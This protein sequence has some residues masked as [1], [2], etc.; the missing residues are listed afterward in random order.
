MT[1]FK[2]KKKANEDGT[3]NMW[4]DPF[5]NYDGKMKMLI[6]QN[7]LKGPKALNVPN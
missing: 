1:L 6:C 7:K 5:K 3:Y 4:Q 2:K